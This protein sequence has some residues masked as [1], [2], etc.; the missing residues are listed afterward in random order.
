[1]ENLLLVLDEIDDL[2]S[3]FGLIWR[4]F[5]SLVFAVALFV[6]TGFIFVT[7][8]KTVEIVAIALV[9]FGLLDMVRQRLQSQA[10]ANARAATEEVG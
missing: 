9:G 7:L 6:A 2:F 4:P 3:M 5:V 8:P 1:M 10:T